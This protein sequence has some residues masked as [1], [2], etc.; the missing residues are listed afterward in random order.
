MPCTDDLIPG[1]DLLLAPGVG[2]VN[3][4]PDADATVYFNLSGTVVEFSGSGYHDKVSLLLMVRRTVLSLTNYL[5]LELGK[6]TPRLQF[7]QL[8]LGPWSSRSLLCCL[9]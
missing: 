4:M 6:C 2:W 7:P 3:A 5:D 8:V 9:V 1:G